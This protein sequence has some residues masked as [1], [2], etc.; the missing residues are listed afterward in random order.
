MVAH[1]RAAADD[2]AAALFRS[3]TLL[4]GNAKRYENEMKSVG[5]QANLMAAE[6][7]DWFGSLW[8]GRRLALTLAV[9]AL[10]GF[11]TCFLLRCNR[12]SCIGK[13]AMAG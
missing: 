13:L 2:G 6:F 4:S 1:Q 5:G 10:G 11:L 8:H 12:V 9:L 3:G 7:Q